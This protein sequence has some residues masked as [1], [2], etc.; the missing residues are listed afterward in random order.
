[1]TPT[2]TDE[3]TRTIP[4]TPDIVK[5]LEEQRR[6]Q[7]EMRMKAG[8]SWQ[9]HG[10]VFTNEIGEPLK[11][12]TVRRIYKKICVEAGLPETFSPKV[13][14]HSCASALLNDEVP[15]KM[16]SERLGHSSIQITADVYSVVEDRRQR[17]VSER[18]ER[19]FGIG[20]KG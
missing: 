10:F 16:I 8:A 5:G 9:D 7:L 6:R 13:A 19:L 20:K 4:I 15:L 12:Y 3:S 2:K 17:E 14:R 11:L 18:V 1:V